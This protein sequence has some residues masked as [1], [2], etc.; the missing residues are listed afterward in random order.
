MRYRTLVLMCLGGLVSS[1]ASVQAQTQAYLPQ[2]GNGT[3]A[4]GSMRTTFVLFNPT[5]VVVTATIYL[6]SDN[7]A[8]L[9]VTIPG[10]GTGS[11]FGPFTLQP[12]QFM[13]PQTDGSGPL[14]AGAARI[15]S[16]SPI[17]VSAIFTI[18]GSAQDFLTEA[19]VGDS[20]PLDQFVI[21]VDCTGSFNTGV[22]LFNFNTAATSVTYKLVDLSGAQVATAGNPMTDL[23]VAGGHVAR[24]FAGPDG[25][26]PGVTNFRGTLVMTST[27][28]VAAVTLRQNGAPL[29]NTTLP[30]VSSAETRT[31]FNLPQVANGSDSVSGFTMRTT[32]IVFNVSAVPAVVDFTLRKPDATPLAVTIPGAVTNSATFSRNLAPGAAAFLQTDGSGAL[33]VGSA[34]VSSNTPV[35]VAAIFTLFGPGA[36]F[37]TEAGVGDSP[38]RALFSLPVDVTGNFNT[39]VAMF[40]ANA[41][42]V[43][44]MASLLDATGLKVGDATP[45]VLNPKS[46]QA[47]FVTELF[48]GTVGFRGLLGIN[49]VGGVAAVTVRQNGSPVSYT[50][51]P[52]ADGVSQ[53]T[54]A[55]QALLDD[56]RDNITATA[57]TT[58]NVQ[59]AAGFKLSGTIT[60]AARL[61]SSVTVTNTTGGSFVAGYN[62]LDSRYEAIV[63]AGTYTVHVCYAPQTV[64]LQ[65]V[66]TLSY[67]DPSPVQVNADTTRNI[68]IPAPTLR[69]VSGTV[70]GV[71]QLPTNSGAFL[72]FTTADGSAGGFAPVAG[73]GSYDIQL[74]NGT[75]TASLV[76]SDLVAPPN[77]NQTALSMYNIGS[78]V[79]NNAAVAAN[80]T[81]PTRAIV[82]GVASRIG[83]ENISPNSFVTAIDTSGPAQTG[84]TCNFAAT[85]SA[86]PVDP[87]P[88]FDVQRAYQMTLATGRSYKLQ[89]NFPV[90]TGGNGAFP[91][92]GQLVGPLTQNVV[93][94]LTVPALP[95]TVII[96]GTVTNPQAQGVAGVN[97]VATSSQISSAA[98]VTFTISGVT[99]AGGDYSLTVP[100]GAGYQLFFSPPKPQP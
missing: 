78:F 17:G 50:T 48:P 92:N 26:F 30:V 1:L 97:V 81:L 62:V 73:N 58:V 82:S 2:V 94:F 37:L 98:G 53:G 10:L 65:S 85:S 20:P 23:L 21:P 74:P 93:Q 22:A 69:A 51:L 39:A 63:P 14:V 11:V 56:M 34:E 3:Y 91:T 59:L 66:P 31:S 54:T 32:F 49:A 86:T 29:S 46:Q 84:L 28:P 27:L 4:G 45:F 95:A 61:V 87:S 72:N 18:Y 12:G 43:L 57:A 13:L 42:P 77:P 35:G 100:S 5:D 33:S 76:A 75:Y 68:T 70:T 44:V 6:T 25:L 47:R 16:S 19:G 79:V 7:S 38:V 71:N 8:P 41:V 67:A 88:N 96:S 60:G 24:F 15:E 40:N 99:D 89:L 9:S 64:S 83:T 90:G 52:V 80:F 36:A 55:T